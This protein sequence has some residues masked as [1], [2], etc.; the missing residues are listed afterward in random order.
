MFI[1]PKT[2]SEHLCIMFPHARNEKAMTAVYM[3]IK[4][5]G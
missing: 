3:K 1:L 5:S 2:F 4:T